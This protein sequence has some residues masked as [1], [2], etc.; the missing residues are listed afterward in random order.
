MKLR[1]PLPLA[2]LTMF[3]TLAHASFTP[4]QEIKEK[5]PQAKKIIDSWKNASTKAEKRTVHVVYWSPAD[6]QP[7][8]KHRERLTRVMQEA[9]KFY[10][11]GMDKLGFG[12]MS[13]SL[14]LDQDK[15]LRIHEVQGKHPYTHYRY[16]SGNEIRDECR[17]T[18]EK[19]GLDLNQETIVLFCNMSNW[20][21]EKKR[22]TQNSPYY[23]GGTP[24]N[25]CAWQVDSPILDPIYLTKQEPKVHD[26]QYGHISIGKYNSIF[27]GGVIHE[28]GHALGLPHC[29]ARADE[30][31]RWGTA[32]MGLGNHTYAEDLRG[33][34]KGTFLT[35]TN[36]LRLSTHPLFTGHRQEIETR[37]TS[38][39]S[40]LQARND[41]AFG[42]KSFSI[43]G[44][45]HTPK[46][47]APAYAI[48]A[49]CDPE[50]GKNYDATT[51]TAIPDKQGRFTLHCTDLKAGKKAQL[52]LVILHCNGDASSHV[53][54]YSP[55]SYDYYVDS[56]GIPHIDALNFAMMFSEVQQAN[57][58]KK[59]EQRKKALESLS[60]SKVSKAATIAKRLLAEQHLEGKPASISKQKKSIALGDTEPDQVRNGYGEPLYNRMPSD[61]MI[62][63]ASGQTFEHG[64]Y[65]HAPARHQYALAGQWKRLKGQCGLAQNSPG[66]VRFIIRADGK[67]L[68]RSAIMRA[69]TLSSY[70]VDLS[71]KQSLELIVEDAGD[72]NRSDWGLWLEPTLER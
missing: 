26:G 51:A 47:M 56:K 27:C 55:F 42:E 6:R 38:S 14:D 72:G 9:R 48:L 29:C 45:I 54:P 40:H 37:S 13:I 49:Y 39:L 3:G 71:G 2:C 4:E 33:E 17:P 31:Q 21:P 10:S 53:G 8:P 11:N 19:A 44:S 60:R 62:L 63:Q 34:G 24:R 36:G 41:P 64:V 25:G 32:L 61:S 70:D 65:A 15:L 18:L 69:N 58:D 66:S 20:A 46:N 16:N 35:L 43:T 5:V 68:W 1:F 7:A 22:I 59:P 28:L 52:R 67:E 50:G 30:K 23:A 12:P 57:R